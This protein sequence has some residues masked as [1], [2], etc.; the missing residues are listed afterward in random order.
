M[1][2]RA[3][4][5]LDV[6]L[7]K[8]YEIETYFERMTVALGGP[9]LKPREMQS[10]RWQVIKGCLNFSKA[11]WLRTGNAHNHRLW[12]ALF[13][14]TKID[15]LMVTAKEQPEKVFNRS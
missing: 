5:F 2:F 4:F 11:K 13:R 3:F 14:A 9:R 6:L 7:N 8:A 1:A 15:L 10:K 12:N